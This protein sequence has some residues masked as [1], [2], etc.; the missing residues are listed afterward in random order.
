VTL[1]PVSVYTEW[2]RDGEL[3]YCPFCGHMG[4]VDRAARSNDYYLGDARRCHDCGH[5]FYVTDYG[6][7][8]FEDLLP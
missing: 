7:H 2:S 6:P 5:Q 4:S 1:A 8:D 3:R